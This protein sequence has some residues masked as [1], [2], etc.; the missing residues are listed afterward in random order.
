[1]SP[2]TTIKRHVCLLSVLT[3][4]ALAMF[5][6]LFFGLN[7]PEIVRHGW[8]ITLCTILD[9]HIDQRFCCQED[10][11]CKDAPSG[12]LACSSVVSQIDQFNPPQCAADPSSCPAT[13]GVCNGGYLCCG[14]C[15]S[16]CSSCSTSCFSTGNGGQSCSTSCTSYSRPN[17]PVVSVHVVHPLCVHSA[18]IPVQSAIRMSSP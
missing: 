5:F 8:P 7:Y 11:H 13:S 10:C 12:A 14:E 16:T 17:S 9:S 2:L 3:V 18:R 15:C 1:M 4:A 6:G